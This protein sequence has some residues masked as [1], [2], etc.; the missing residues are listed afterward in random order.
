MSFTLLLEMGYESKRV[1]ICLCK[2]PGQK[3][4][5]RFRS[6]GEGYRD[7]DLERIF[8]E[9]RYKMAIPILKNGT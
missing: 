5:L 1:E 2:R 8:K 3:K 6:L 4:Y 7:E 9:N